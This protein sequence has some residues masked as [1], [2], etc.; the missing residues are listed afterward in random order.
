MSRRQRAF[1]E[2]IYLI[3]MEPVIKDD[4][5]IFNILG[6]TGNKYIITIG[7]KSTCTCFDH[8]TRNITCKHI[9]FVIYRICK[10]TYLL[11]NNLTIENRKNIFANI[12]SFIDSRLL[13][14]SNVKKIIE[15]IS[16]RID[17]CCPIC[18]NDLKNENIKLLNY[19]QFGC[20]KSY[21]KK[22]FEICNKSK[23]TENC[24]FCRHKL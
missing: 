2:P 10:S 24:A 13:A 9:Y 1:N 22:C 4:E 5:R 21:H 14:S 16:Q 20:G 23:F 19:C 8:R 3:D 12:P 6:K 7:S 17:D 11:E 18:L 15:K